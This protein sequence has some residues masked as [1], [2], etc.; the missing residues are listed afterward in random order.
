MRIGSIKSGRI[1]VA[2]TVLALLAAAC[3]G[4][5][6]TRR[7]RRS[8]QP[9]RPRRGHRA[10]PAPGSARVGRAGRGLRARL[11]H[12]RVRVVR[13]GAHQRR[14][15]PDRGGHQPRPAARPHLGAG[16]RGHRGR[17]R[18]PGGQDL[19]RAAQGRDPGEHRSP[20][21][22]LPRLHDGVVAGERLA[23]RAVGPRRRHPGQPRRQ[24]RGADLPG[25][26]PGPG[27]GD[28]REP[29]RGCRSAPRTS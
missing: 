20:V 2:I 6:A 21:P 23:A 13:E 19:H 29:V 15:L 4:S 10:A 26:G 3:G 7:P 27:P 12:R 28:L 5:A 9:R 24:G 17:P 16:L 11:L 8:A 1:M 14:A 22:D 18:R 25:P